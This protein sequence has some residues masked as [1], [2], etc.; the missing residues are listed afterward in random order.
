[1]KPGVRPRQGGGGFGP[2]LG[3]LNEHLDEDAMQ[4]AVQQKSLGQQQ[5]DPGQM[6]T[7]GQS[8]SQSPLSP[9]AGKSQASKPR[10]VS[11]KNELKWM[12]Q[13][14][15]KGLRS[16]FDLN[17]AL[18]VDPVQDSPEEQAKKK[19][20]HQ[21]YD[22]LSQEERDYA[23]KLYQQKMEKKKKEE[24][25]AQI[26]KQQEEEQKAQEVVVPSS[27]QKGPKGPAG[28]SRKQ[29]AVNKLQQ[30]RQSMGGPGSHN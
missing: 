15:I 21:R 26:K 2:G 4:Q 22:R 18:G 24:E 1:M 11:P 12:G 13:D 25:E 3:S 19:Q 10:P 8:Q 17:A 7:A 28:A 30:Q 20:F 9:G 27:P 14:I 23:Q 16:L 5:A 6:P 29:K